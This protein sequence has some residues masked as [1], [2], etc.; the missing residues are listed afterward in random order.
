MRSMLS[1]GHRT[2]VG[3]KPVL[4]KKDA[5]GG[6]CKDRDKQNLRKALQLQILRKKDAEGGPCKDRDLVLV[7]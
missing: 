4:G 5:E 6:L 2:R 3:F 7:F 1:P